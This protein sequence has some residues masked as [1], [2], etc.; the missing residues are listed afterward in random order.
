MDAHNGDLLLFA[1]DS[2]YMIV[3]MHY[4]QLEII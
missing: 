3:S 1:A 2:H 4:Q